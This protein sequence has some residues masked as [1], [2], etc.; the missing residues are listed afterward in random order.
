MRKVKALTVALATAGLLFSSIYVLSDTKNQS[1]AV[2]PEQAKQ[3]KKFQE[4]VQQI[5]I[6]AKQKG[7]SQQTI[8]KYLTGLK[9]PEVR[10]L[11]S[12]HN[13]PQDK[14][15]FKQYSESFVSAEKVKQGRELY[16]KYYT[17]LKH[18]E[19]KYKV[20]GEII[21]AIWGDESNY[22]QGPGNK[23]I[24][25]SLVTLSFQKHRSQFY[26]NELFAALKILNHQKIKE[27]AYSYFDGGMGQPS[28]MPSVYYA[29]A[30]DY[31]H[32]GF[33]N[34]WTSVPDVLASIANYLH[35]NG[36]RDQQ[37]WVIPVTVPPNF[38]KRYIG[39]HR[40]LTLAQWRKLGIRVDDKTINKTRLRAS[41]LVP[42]EGSNHGYLVFYNY[43]VLLRWNN[44]MFECLSIGILA[45][46]I[47]K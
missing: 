30:V 2:S 9:A 40:A 16:Q 10:I 47:A 39:K 35:K 13:Q 25:A 20:P 36:W 11:H 8:D 18:I 1:V 28:F 6:E 15:T 29:Y 37:P 22:G 31:D 5:R 32:N 27:Q 12:L 24:I 41:L 45:N 46:E 43:K 19:K 38:S 17:L 14:L 44:T 33:A 21:V 34:I 42:D 3:N 23:P 26:R 4:F 7:I